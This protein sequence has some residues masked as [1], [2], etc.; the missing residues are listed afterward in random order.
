MTN[1]NDLF[2]RKYHLSLFLSLKDQET[3]V[4][5]SSLPVLI[6]PV[7]I[8]RLL[9]HWILSRKISLAPVQSKGKASSYRGRRPVV[10][11]ELSLPADERAITQL[12]A[13]LLPHVKTSLSY[14]SF[15]SF[16]LLSHGSRSLGSYSRFTFS[17]S[18]LG[19][20]ILRR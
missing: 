16:F 15:F 4:P 3:Q 2:V 14:R 6:D 9:H 19:G 17:K 7:I 1:G 12:E 20:Y 11:R 8:L 13:Q 10:R 18:N 5:L